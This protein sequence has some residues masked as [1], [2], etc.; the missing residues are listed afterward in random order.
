[1]QKIAKHYG[2]T[3]K[4]LGLEMIQMVTIKHSRSS[5]YLLSSI[6]HLPLSHSTLSS[7]LACL[8]SIRF[9]VL[10]IV[11]TARRPSTEL[12]LDAILL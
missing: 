4:P 8:L 1:M 3:P 11:I 5:F 2:C 10:C 12:M 7:F 6:F 9:V